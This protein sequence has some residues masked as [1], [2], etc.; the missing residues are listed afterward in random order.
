MCWSNTEATTSGQFSTLLTQNTHEQHLLSGGSGLRRI[1]EVCS[2]V[3][4]CNTVL[5]VFI[6]WREGACDREYLF[7]HIN[8]QQTTF[9]CFISQPSSLCYSLFGLLIYVM[10]KRR[11]TEDEWVKELLRF[12][13]LNAIIWICQ[14]DIL[15]LLLI[16]FYALTGLKKKLGS[17]YESCQ[18][19]MDT[20][21]KLCCGCKL[22]A[23]P[24]G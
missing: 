15:L 13:T 22:S 10:L 1:E 8:H 11:L 2:F 3:C 9:S 5:Y 19:E 23:M 4:V 16:G 24:D 21:C 14:D 17:R 6:A 7:N 18:T 12:L 20:F